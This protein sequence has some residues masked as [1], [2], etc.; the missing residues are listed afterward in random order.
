MRF[1]GVIIHELLHRKGKSHAN[2]A[3][4]AQKA[5][6]SEE[7]KKFELKDGDAAASNYISWWLNEKC[8]FNP[9]DPSEVKANVVP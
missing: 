3:E 8:K 2:M 7:R 9:N 5:L 6:T 4:A 1:V